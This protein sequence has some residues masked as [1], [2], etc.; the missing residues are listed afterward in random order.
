M[1][2]L[3]SSPI[4]V[5]LVILYIFAKALLDL[6]ILISPLAIALYRVT[7]TYISALL[8][9]FAYHC[10]QGMY[11]FKPRAEDGCIDTLVGVAI[12]DICWAIVAI[13][14]RLSRICE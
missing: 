13:T 6:L 4:I 14:G 7:K 11:Y 12:A 10:N 3:G 9:V 5:P 2:H 8:V 1:K